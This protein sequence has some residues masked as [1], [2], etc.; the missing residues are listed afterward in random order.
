MRVP[1]FISALL[2]QLMYVKRP[3]RTPMYPRAARVREHEN[4]Q[5]TPCDQNDAE[6]RF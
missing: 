6:G 2:M 3:R 1:G 4:G 5:I